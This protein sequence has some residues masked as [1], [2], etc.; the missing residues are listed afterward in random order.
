MSRAEAKLI[1]RVIYKVDSHEKAKEAVIHSV[2]LDGVQSGQ[3]M[4]WNDVSMNIPAIPPTNLGGCCSIID[5]SYRL[6]FHVLPSGIEY[7][8][9]IVPNKLVCGLPI[10]IGVIPLRNITRVRTQIHHTDG[11]YNH[12]VYCSAAF[13]ESS[14]PSAPD[15]LPDDEYDVPPPTYEEA[16]C[17]AEKRN[18]DILRTIKKFRR[19]TDTRDDCRP[20]YPMSFQTH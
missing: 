4:T 11:N 14:E 6:E 18:F 13:Q 17:I 15:I 19:T 10:I 1:Q 3:T 12:P 8:V 5:L 20:L 2:Q 9:G 16:T 7:L